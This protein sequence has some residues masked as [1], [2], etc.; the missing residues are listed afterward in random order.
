[1]DERQPQ[2]NGERF[3]DVAL[4]ANAECDEQRAQPLAALLLQAQRA[5]EP[6]DVELAPLDQDFAES[7]SSRI[8]HAFVVPDT[9]LSCAGRALYYSTA[10]WQS[11]RQAH[12]NQCVGTFQSDAAAAAAGTAAR[13][14]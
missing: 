3:G 2:L 5:L 4:G 9:G 12:K 8:V 14:C 13:A 11:L 1:V 7:P 6:G 10:Q